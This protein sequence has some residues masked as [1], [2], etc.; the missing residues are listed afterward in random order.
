MTEE[1]SAEFLEFSEML[2]LEGQPPAGTEHGEETSILLELRKALREEAETTPLPLSFAKTTAR[3]ILDN[4]NTRLPISGWKAALSN[5]LFSPL[6]RPRLALTAVSGSGLV[7]ILALFHPKLL[8]AVALVALC[9][10]LLGGAILSWTSWKPELPWS[11]SAFERATILLPTVV[12]ILGATAVGK[13]TASLIFYIPSETVGAVAAAL[14]AFPVVLWLGRRLAGVVQSSPYR[15]YASL[16]IQAVSLLSLCL[17]LDSKPSGSPWTQEHLAGGVAA[18]LLTVLLLPLSSDASI[19]GLTLKRLFY[20]L[21]AFDAVLTALL[22]GS[23][24]VVVGQLSFSFQNRSVQLVLGAVALSFSLLLLIVNAA[25]TYWSAQ[26]AQASK[27]PWRSLLFQMFHLAW[28]LGLVHLLSSLMEGRDGPSTLGLSAFKGLLV[29]TAFLSW[30]LAVT[31]KEA[32]PS[33]LSLKQARNHAAKSLLFGM[34]PL[35][36]AGYLFYQ[37]TLTRDIF[38]PTYRQMQQDVEEWRKQQK[39]VATTENGWATIRPYFVRSG[40]ERPENAAVAKELK[41]LSNFIT[42]TTDD[43]DN[44]LKRGKREEFG[45]AKHAFLKHIPIL[46]EAVNKPHFS[47]VA[48]EGHTSVSQAPDFIG[49]RAVSQAFQLLF[50]EQMHSGDSRQSL[51]YAKLGLAWSSRLESSSLIN[52]MIRIAQLNISIERLE[53]GIVSGHFNRSQLQDLS[54]ALQNSRP[55]V[56]EFSDAM[57]RGTVLFDD[58]FESILEGENLT[59]AFSVDVPEWY[60]KLMPKSYWQSE[61]NAYWN[62][63]LALCYTWWNLALPEY[64]ETGD[65]P[66]LNFTSNLLVAKSH[67]AQSQFC[68]LHSRMSALIVLCQLERYRLDH[69]FYPQ[70]LDELVPRYLSE[71]PED[72]MKPYI[73]GRKGGFEYLPTGGSYRLISRSPAYEQVSLESE[74][75][76]GPA[77]GGASR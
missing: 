65:I 52:L 76:Y 1:L 22:V 62:N 64:S 2:D 43:Y 20:A 47:T 11:R 59:G 16:T 50:L 27:A 77:T 18:G 72:L 25:R 9:G 68:Y 15:I 37:M 12:V 49:L 6:N 39:S 33:E 42:G 55:P 7:G 54:T 3:S 51:H 13:Q 69:G 29:M 10:T 24:V 21:P 61:R 14:V 32:I 75:V 31:K 17:I 35:I 34:L 70:T 5:A 48:I 45:S 41:L 71:L 26:L 74:Q 40:L 44:I 73:I 56:S 60:L 4:A 57:E 67:R 30:G 66:F 38:D 36:A 28:G 46:E 58:V 8:L 23:L 19:A 53:T 63:Q